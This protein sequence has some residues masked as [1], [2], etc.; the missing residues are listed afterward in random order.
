VND[1][2]D[3][4][5]ME[6][7]RSIPNVNVTSKHYDQT[8]LKTII[9]EYDVLVV[10]SATKANREIIEAG[11]N[12]KLIARAG[13]GLDNVDTKAAKE[14]NIKV[15][16]TPGANAISVAELAIG[17][18]LSMFRHIARG[19]AG[20]KDGKWEKKELEGCELYGKTIGI[21]GFGAIGKEIAKRLLAFDCK[22]LAYDVMPD[23]GGLQVTFASLE[24]IYKD[25]DVITIHTPLI[26]PTKHMIDE[27]AI[28]QMKDGV[29]I[30]HAA[31]GGIVDESALL[32]ALETGKVAGAALDVFEVEPPTDDLRKKLIAHP[33]VIGTPHIGASTG[34][35]QERVG[36]Q[37]VASLKKEIAK[38]VL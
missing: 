9:P 10:R 12:L 19:T 2:L 27:K 13:T 30:V 21:I 20:L 6:V 7:L 26:E 18:M 11:K 3:A 23:A 4:A 1:P 15:I 32:K 35:A 14:K 31:R 5:A 22:I 8:E 33:K 24:E 25:S 37:I 16:N 38:I 29:Y 36:V 17:F 34:E 28:N